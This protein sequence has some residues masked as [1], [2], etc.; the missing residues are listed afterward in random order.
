MV[1]LMR[2]GEAEDELATKGSGRRCLASV[3]A[4]EESQ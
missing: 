3:E 2:H 1:V 4:R